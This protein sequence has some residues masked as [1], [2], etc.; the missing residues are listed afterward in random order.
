MEMVVTVVFKFI[1][2]N[3]KI[4]LLEFLKAEKPT[5]FDLSHDFFSV[6]VP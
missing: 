4:N 3:F 1:L 6:N 2:N 5:H